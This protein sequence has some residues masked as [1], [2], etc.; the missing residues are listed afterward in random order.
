MLVKIKKYVICINS[1]LN[2]QPYTTRGI[3]V[4]VKLQ[5]KRADGKRADRVKQMDADLR[6]LA[7]KTANEGSQK[8]LGLDL[9]IVGLPSY[10][11]RFPPLIPPFSTH[12]YFLST[13]PSLLYIAKTFAPKFLFDNTWK[14]LS[15]YGEF[16]PDKTWTAFSSL[17]LNIGLATKF[18][19]LTIIVAWKLVCYLL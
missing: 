7:T 9:L 19:F 16:S 5:L 1:R 4:K 10:Y 18:I 15:F 14:S 17:N 12:I 3:S 11:I 6:T 2:D 13:S 8:P